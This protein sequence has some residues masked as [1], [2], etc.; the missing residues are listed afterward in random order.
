MNHLLV[1]KQPM[2]C[3][4]CDERISLSRED[5]ARQCATCA[6]VLEDSMSAESMF[7]NDTLAELKHWLKKTENHRPCPG[8][9]GINGLLQS[10]KSSSTSR[11]RSFVA[12][13]P[14]IMNSLNI[15][16]TRNAQHATLPNMRTT[17]D[18]AHL[19]EDIT[20][21]H[22]LFQASSSSTQPPLPIAANQAEDTTTTP[23]DGAHLAETPQIVWRHVKIE[24]KTR[25]WRARQIRQKIHANRLLPLIFEDRGDI[26]EGIAKFL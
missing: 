23:S 16:P 20:T 4:L 3:E 19:A 2:R 7:G 18:G 25:E 9:R 8:I 12:K 24:I 15:D 26:L 17:S 6:A 13:S 1:E 22:C 5:E 10:S 21:K 14:S 11:G